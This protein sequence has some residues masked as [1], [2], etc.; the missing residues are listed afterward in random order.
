MKARIRKICLIVMIT[1]TVFL[2]DA[3]LLLLKKIRHI[4]IFPAD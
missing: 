2:V 4:I 1:V 3:F